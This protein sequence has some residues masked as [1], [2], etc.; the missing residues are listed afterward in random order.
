MS[1]TWFWRSGWWTTKNVWQL[2]NRV[3]TSGSW[4][5]A[6]CYDVVGLNKWSS[7]NWT[8]VELDVW[9]QRSICIILFSIPSCLPPCGQ[10]RHKN[11]LAFCRNAWPGF[12]VIPVYT[13]INPKLTSGTAGYAWPCELKYEM[14]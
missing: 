9:P 11:P 1:L 13:W 3:F 6:L 2:Q 12:P 8:S 4:H 7:V 5:R 14:H 10:R